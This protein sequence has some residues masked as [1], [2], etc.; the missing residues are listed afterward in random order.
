MLKPIKVK[1]PANIA[2]VKHWGMSL[3]GLPL[4]GSLSMNLSNCTTTT[5]IEENSAV[6][7]DQVFIQNYDGKTKTI[8]QNIDQRDD[9][10]FAQI[11][12]IRALSGSDE[13][14]KITSS[15]NFPTKSGIASSASGFSA[16]TFGL[17]NFYGL[18]L[19]V[20]NMAR[21]VAKA[22]SISAVR[23][24]CNNFGEVKLNEAGLIEVSDCSEFEKFDL[25]DIIA[26]VDQGEKFSSSLN[27]QRVA[28]TSPFFDSR[29]TEVKRNLLDIKT[30]AKKRFFSEVG[31]IIELEA[32]MLHS[33]MLTSNPAQK[34]INAKTLEVV[35]KVLELRRAG[36]ECFFTIDAGANVHIITT[37]LNQEVVVENMRSLKSVIDLIV[38]FPCKGTEIIS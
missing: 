29:I 6:G 1:S 32:V 4:A 19:D 28:E 14:V 12:L 35:D 23:S 3:E 36:V 37:K 34:Y 20:N 30:A 38:N 9:K 26:I 27:G 11:E 22:G 25:I 17:C 10:V 8:I 15:N 24:L 31:R 21:L 16:L 7:L 2:F 18:D 33:V 13:K 5:N